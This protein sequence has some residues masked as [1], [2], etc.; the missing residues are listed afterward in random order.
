MSTGAYEASMAKNIYIFL[1]LLNR[2]MAGVLPQETL[3]KRKQRNAFDLTG[4]LICFL[5]TI[6]CLIL[7]ATHKFWLRHQYLILP[8]AIF[9]S[10]YGVFAVIS[11]AFSPLLKNECSLFFSE[12]ALFLLRAMK[13]FDFLG[14][15]RTVYLKLVVFRMKFLR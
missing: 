10:S 6:A 3:K 13:V 12:I 4:H 11:C 15:F 8:R 9:L 2:S 1:E 7:S 5:L 14:L